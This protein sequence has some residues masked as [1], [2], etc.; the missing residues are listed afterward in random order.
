M[1]LKFGSLGKRSKDV[2]APL[3]LTPSASNRRYSNSSPSSSHPSPE[4]PLLAASLKHKASFLNRTVRRHDSML[5]VRAVA[6]GALAGDRTSIESTASSTHTHESDAAQSF[7]SSETSFSIHFPADKGSARDEEDGVDTGSEPCPVFSESSSARAPPLPSALP[8]GVD[9]LAMEVANVQLLELLRAKS[10]PSFVEWDQKPPRLI[11][12]I[13]AGVKPWSK[14]TFAPWPHAK[15]TSLDVV[16]RWSYFLGESNQPSSHLTE[17]LPY[18]DSSFDYVRVSAYAFCIPNWTWR[19]LLDEIYR[20][21]CYGGRLEIVQD[22]HVF[23]MIPPPTSEESRAQSVRAEEDDDT[24]DELDSEATRPLRGSKAAPKRRATTGRWQIFDS[25]TQWRDMSSHCR[26]METLFNKRLEQLDLHQR[27][28]LYLIEALASA[29]GPNSVTMHHPIELH[30]PSREYMESV[31][32]HTDVPDSP[33]MRGGRTMLSRT[34]EPRA[35]EDR[36]RDSIRVSMVSAS[37]KAA[38]LLGLGGPVAPSAYMP[39]GLI[40]KRH[41]QP[42]RL[43]EMDPAMLEAHATRF[44][45]VLTG[46]EEQLQ[47]YFAKICEDDGSCVLHENDMSDSVWDYQTFH[48]RRLNMPS[49]NQGDDFK[50]DFRQENRSESTP[51]RPL[52][53]VLVRPARAL[54]DRRERPRSASG[55]PSLQWHGLAHSSALPLDGGLTRVRAFRIFSAVKS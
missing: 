36:S 8:Y 39:P 17:Q 12:D 43:L 34:P 3:D 37:D 14:A 50:D 49:C 27:R 44:P 13:G 2:P 5:S 40:M 23:P 20:V 48:R 24:E 53:A 30:V 32:M 22:V 6:L 33:L 4:F 52:S 46:Y 18:P 25:A 28:P 9:L 10:S 29:F 15:V 7:A 41:G 16:Q 55:K 21:L 11:L 38:R 35:L 47:S 45:R 31:R 54:S 1:T 19:K 42:S 51:E 26:D